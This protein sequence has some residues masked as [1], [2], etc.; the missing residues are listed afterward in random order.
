LPLGPLVA[1]RNVLGCDW[2]GFAAAANLKPSFTTERTATG[3]N[4]LP[5]Q[6]L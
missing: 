4:L 5:Q 1:G 2:M 6:Q 3:S